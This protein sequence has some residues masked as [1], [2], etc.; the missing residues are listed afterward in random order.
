MGGPRSVGS[1]GDDGDGPPRAGGVSPALYRARWG[2]EGP[3]DRRKSVEG[4]RTAG[5]SGALSCSRDG[6]EE[7][8]RMGPR[9]V[10][11]RTDQGGE[12]R[13]NPGDVGTTGSSGGVREPLPVRL[14][15]DGS[16]GAFLRRRHRLRLGHRGVLQP[17]LP[18]E[19]QQRSPD[20]YGWSVNSSTPRPRWRRRSRARSR[21]P[22]DGSTR[23]W[24]S[25]PAHLWSSGTRS[26]RKGVG[27]E[28]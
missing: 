25:R 26:G 21:S 11:R 9:P 23:S 28:T 4:E 3:G 1:S 16:A 6:V 18:A 2:S 24:C 14:L 27:N 5:E 20:G 12:A 22:R 7:R 13:Q 19:E 15:H 17:V 10:P 8:G